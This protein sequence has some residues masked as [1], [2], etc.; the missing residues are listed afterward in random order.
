MQRNH[1]RTAPIALLIIV[2]SSVF[3]LAGCSNT[4]TYGP[5]NN[6]GLAQIED[7]SLDALAIRPGTDFNAYQKILIE[8]LTVSY[9]DKR[10]HDRLNQRQEDFEFDDREL[11]IFNRQF[12]KAIT[13]SWQQQFGWEA[14]DQPGPG[15][16]RVSASIS[17]LYLYASIKN[18]RILPSAVFTN[19][20]SDMEI[21]LSL[22][23]AQSGQLLLDSKDKRTTGERGIGARSMQRTNSVTYWQDSYQE[24]RQL[25]TH[26]STQIN[27]LQGQ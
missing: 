1:S 8:P 9:S 25:A 7:H 22:H 15:V 24:F 27:K 26:L 23:D 5:L 18:D 11:E 2:I 19:E 4:P 13:S 20:S 12:A 3:T 14:T 6:L 16:I 17:D 21:Q 10:R